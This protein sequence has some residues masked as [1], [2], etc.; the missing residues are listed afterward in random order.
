M[1]SDAAPR[2]EDEQDYDILTTSETSST[3][4]DYTSP[5]SSTTLIDD[6][7]Y[8]SINED[9]D[10]D[11]D[12]Y[13]GNKP[14]GT[15]TDDSIPTDDPAVASSV[16]VPHLPMPDEHERSDLPTFGPRIVGGTNARLGEFQG[17]I[18]VQTR[19]GGYHFCGG[20]IIDTWHVATAAHCVCN[21]MRVVRVPSAV[22]LMGDDLEVGQ[23]PA[24]P[25]RQ[26]RQAQLIFVHLDYN[27]D[28]LLNDIAI[29]RVGN[30]N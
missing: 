17:Q 16:E 23:I 8:N 18:S 29:I 12:D 30:T 27:P 24:N 1:L 9:D 14:T 5:N 10:D 21:S 3:D 20:T 4:Y 22:Q 28:N 15:T 6:D 11:G 19:S 2:S 25:G 13:G 26:V 7:D